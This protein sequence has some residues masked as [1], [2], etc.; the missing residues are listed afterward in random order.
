MEKRTLLALTLSFL[1]LG[2]Y[3][4]ILQKIYPDYKGPA[5]SAPKAGFIKPASPASPALPH[6]AAVSASAAE[7]SPAG[8]ILFENENL[9]LVFNKKGG[10]LREIAF[11]KFADSE[12]QRPLRLVSLEDSGQAPFAA[13]I[14][15][16]NAGLPAEAAGDYEVRAA[17]PENILAETVLGGKLKIKK[18]LTFGAARYDGKL[19]L[20][21]QNNSS[22]AIEFRYALV[23]GPD[24]PPRHSIDSQYLESN[25]YSNAGGRPEIR[26]VKE[27]KLGKSVSSLVPPE[28]VAV[29]DRHFSILVKPLSGGGFTGLVQGLGGHRSKTSLVSEKISVL[30][31]SSAEHEF[32]I[33][34]GPNEL[35]ELDP[36]GLGPLVNFGKLDAI[37]KILVGGLELLHKIF[38]NYGLSIIALTVLINLLLFPFTRVSYLSMK[39]MQLVQ[40]QMTRLRE[41]HKKNPEKL[42]RETMELYKK[43]KVNPFGGCLPMLIQMPVFIALYV[44]LSKSVILINSKLLWIR[45]L[46]SPD[47]VPLGLSLP[48]LGNSVHILPLLMAAAMALQQKFTQI[49]LEGQDPATESQQKMMAVM[50]PV[51]FGFIFYSMPSGLVLYWLTNTL[52]MTFYQLRLKNM[53]LVS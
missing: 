28:W 23:V 39:R 51:L 26:H 11:K 3:P 27:T 40:P 45:D 24:I 41:Q 5:A 49:K 33:Y 30:A 10:V 37:G 14:L 42:N 7:L 4:V 16:N 48:F 18:T 43:H 52:L 50:M 12:T 34:I 8:D 21:F 36:I 2:F 1:M 13:E 22:E 6:S 32:Q 29:K 9:R 35:Q 20:S 25:F 47:S 19:R 44:A 38:K 15:E 17:D 31:R 46:S 53:T